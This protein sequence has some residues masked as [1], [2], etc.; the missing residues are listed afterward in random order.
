MA[1]PLNFILENITKR[2]LHIIK[3]EAEAL[4]QKVKHTSKLNN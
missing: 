4:G 2:V 1:D 3:T